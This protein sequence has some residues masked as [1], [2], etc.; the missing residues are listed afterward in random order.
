MHQVYRELYLDGFLSFGAGWNNLEMANDILVVESNYVTNTVAL[1]GAFSGAYE[2]N[3]YEL[4]PELAFSYGKTWIGVVDFTGR[5]YGQVD[6]TITSDIGNESVANLTARPEVVIALDAGT[7]GDSHSQ[8]SFAPRLFCE[9]QIAKTSISSCGDG[10]EI[11]IR[12]QSEDGLSSL[13]FRIIS[14]K[15]YGGNRS[16]YTLN[17]DHKF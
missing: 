16:S 14:D 1:G 15:I 2:N 4:R 17:I 8:L 13:N 5:A 3:R 12:S 11:G 9:R 6:A 10:V 7:V